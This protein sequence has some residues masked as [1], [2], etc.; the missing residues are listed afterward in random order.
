MNNSTTILKNKH[1]KFKFKSGL[2][3]RSPSASLRAKEGLSSEALHSR[4]K[5]GQVLVY[6][7]LFMAVIMIMI[8]STY[9]LL[10]SFLSFGSRGIGAEQVTNLADAGADYAV[11]QLGQTSGA[12]PGTGNSGSCVG[13]T[14]INLG[15]GQ[16]TINVQAS[17]SNKKITSTSYIPSC[18]NQKI[19]RVVKVEVTQAQTT[20]LTDIDD[21]APT[22]AHVAIA[23]PTI[24]NCKIVYSDDDANTITFVDC[25][26]SACTLA[27]RTHV[28]ID[29]T[30]PTNAEA[31]VDIY[32]VASADCK[33]VYADTG[34]T[35][36]KFVDCDSENCSSRTTTPLVSWNSTAYS[37]K[38]NISID[39]PA[40]DDCKV[41]LSN[42]NDEFEFYDCNDATCSSRIL[43]YTD[44]FDRSVYS[45]IYCLTSADCKLLLSGNNDGGRLNFINCDDSR[46]SSRTS[47]FIDDR[48]TSN[49]LYCPT[50]DDCKF[51]YNQ[52]SF[53]FVNCG[54]DPTCRPTSLSN[55]LFT[56]NSIDSDTALGKSL[57]CPSPDDCKVFYVDGGDNGAK[58]INCN[59]ISCSSSTSETIDTDATGSLRTDISC[60]SGGSGCGLVYFDRPDN[61]VTFVCYQS[62]CSSS[63]GAWQ[64]RRGT[65][66]ITVN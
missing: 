32:C 56:R 45:S 40:S 53:L 43:G 60:P 8:I 18:A 4:A 52:N 58:L 50:S 23:C 3:F 36:Y 7:L 59:N 30:T 25:G 19:K 1:L 28:D 46:C 37:P 42:D 6:A 21:N 66:K 5:E 24:D 48:Q 61:D 9:S 16:I 29:T 17:G 55:P 31:V 44:N 47:T 33:V 12:Y 35:D 57:F 51:V 62:T 38:T 49:S 41:S 15:A 13:G 2:P 27:N 11:W 65:Y 54:A 14:P 20:V 63:G 34:N 10:G 64:I 26:D 39:C 22:D